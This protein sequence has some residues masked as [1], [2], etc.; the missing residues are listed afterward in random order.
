[1]PPQESSARSSA[2]QP[3]S[4]ER[5]KDCEGPRPLALPDFDRALS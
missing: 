2:A 1:V 5:K 4:N 3:R